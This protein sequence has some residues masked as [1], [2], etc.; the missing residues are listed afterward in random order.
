MQR[1]FVKYDNGLLL[2]KIGGQAV[3]TRDLADR[4]TSLA[5]RRSEAATIVVLCI[6]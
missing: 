6:H 1:F 2:C 4:P 3:A 5:L